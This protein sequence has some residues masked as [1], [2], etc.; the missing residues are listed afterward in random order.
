VCIHILDGVS[1][2]NDGTACEQPIFV[3]DAGAVL[4]TAT[5]A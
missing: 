2:T 3:A 5:R 4:E 1:M